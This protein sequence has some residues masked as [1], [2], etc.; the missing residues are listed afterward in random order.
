M[1]PFTL[2]SL[3]AG[4]LVWFLLH[5]VA[6][7]LAC[8]LMPVRAI[9]RVLAF[10][11]GAL[12]FAVLRDVI[13]GNVSVLLLV[14]LA[15]TWRWLD[16]PAGSAS[17][18]LA[19]ALR[20]TLGVLLAWQLLRGRWLAV[21]WTI[22]AGL[23]LIM[24]SLPFVGLD[25]YADY[26]TVLRNLGEMTGVERNVDAG[27]TAL[28]LGWGEDA[29]RVALFAGYAA[30]IGAIL[31]GLRRDREVGLMVTLGASLL[32][33]PL[34]WDHYL[35]ALL[36]PAAFLAQRGRPLGILLPL[37]S[38]L[39][40]ES[41]PFVVLVAVFLPLWAREAPLASGSAQALGSLAAVAARADAGISRV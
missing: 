7:A 12:S 40:S 15:A 30:A 32:L 39:P 8:W 3:E 19:L 10:A 21:A 4:T 18:A 6:L 2:L 37:L 35:A 29:A 26:L 17:L 33:A 13:L 38:W 41:L 5:V 9:V 25:G 36:L 11:V 34:L 27:T 23:A 16:R 1:G 20:P 24:L 31:L 14:P 22:A 28:N